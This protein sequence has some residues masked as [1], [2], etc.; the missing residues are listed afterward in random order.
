M[1]E[2]MDHLQNPVNSGALEKMA[3]YL[4][5]FHVHERE[6]KGQPAV[7]LITY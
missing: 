6:K 4:T 3:E 2:H 7:F 5:S 1:K